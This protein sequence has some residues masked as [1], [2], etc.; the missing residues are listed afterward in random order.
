[1]IAAPCSRLHCGGA[2]GWR[3]SEQGA[4]DGSLLATGGPLR[5]RSRRILEFRIFLRAGADFEEGAIFWVGVKN[6]KKVVEH[7]PSLMV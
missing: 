5:R 3:Q 4:L 6:K 7:T 1:M 2:G